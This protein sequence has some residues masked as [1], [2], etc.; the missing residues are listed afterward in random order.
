MSNEGKEY[1]SNL[2]ND[3]ELMMKFNKSALVITR[4]LKK[5]YYTVFRFYTEDDIVSDCWCKILAQ[6]ISY[7]ETKGCKFDTFVR[8]IVHGVVYDSWRRIRVRGLD[9]TSSLDA[10]MTAPNGEEY[11]IYDV[12]PDNNNDSYEMISHLSFLKSFDNDI[13][14]IPIYDILVRLSEG[15]TSTKISEEL[16]IDRHDVRRW[17]RHMKDTIKASYEGSETTLS[18]VLYSGDDKL[19]KEKKDAMFSSFR[20]VTSE[21]GVR[22]SDIIKLVMKDYTYSQIGEKVGMSADSVKTFLDKCGSILV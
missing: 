5:K 2:V 9:K 16:G 14:C 12:I 6:D 8:M 17:V 20:Y 21:E 18:D 3:N 15:M 4:S 11:S 1:T 19:Y 13:Y 10:T 22:L 7:D